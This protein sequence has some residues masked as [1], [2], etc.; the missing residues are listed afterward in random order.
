MGKS[1]PSP[2]PATD[3]SKV[4]QAQGQANAETAIS[5]AYLNNVNQNTPYGN[6]NYKVTGQQRVGNNDVPIFTASQDLSP[7]G[8]KLLDT[9]M[10]TT[11]GTADLARRYTDRIGDATSQPFSY[12]GLPGSPSYSTSGMPG[13]PTYS[14]SG[15]PGAPTYNEDYR[16]QQLGAIESRNQPQMDRDR[17]NLEQRLADQGIGLQ[18]AAYTSAMDKYQ[19][20]VNDFRLGADIQAGSSAAQQYSMEADTRD[21]ATRE[22]GQQYDYGAQSRDRAMREASQQYGFDANT[23]DRAIQEMTNLRTQPINEVSAL[24]GTGSGVQNPNF[25][26]TPQ[27]QVAPTDVIGAYGQSAAQQ[28]AAY[29]EQMKANNA[30]TGGLFGL[31]GTVLGAG[32]K[33]GLP[34]LAGSDIRMKENIRHIGHTND[35]QRLYLFTYK[36]DPTTPH[37]GLMAQEVEKSRPDAVVEIGGMK[38]VDYAK[39]LADA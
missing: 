32:L 21:R 25:V 2:P 11:Q 31:G 27:T 29:Q 5:Q 9:N 19:R 30:A 12:D 10:A 33:Y 3:P 24:M 23:R 7:A 13:A 37:V 34:L 6:L 22:A 17:A 35:G 36:H 4:A 26:S 1:T 38:H 8:Q 14:T 20:G 15:A 28:Q 39:A 16:R 18:D